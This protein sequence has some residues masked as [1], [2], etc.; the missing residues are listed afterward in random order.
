MFLTIASARVA[1][2]SNMIKTIS[3][4]LIDEKK[5]LNTVVDTSKAIIDAIKFEIDYNVFVSKEQEEKTSKALEKYRSEE[6]KKCLKKAKNNKTLA[7]KYYT[8]NV[9]A[10]FS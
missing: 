9:D 5:I 2:Y 6:W 1:L 10:L 3:A 4:P 7:Y 8:S